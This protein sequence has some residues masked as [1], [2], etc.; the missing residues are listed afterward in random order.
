M[1][2]FQSIQAQ[3]ESYPSL[4]ALVWSQQLITAICTAAPKLKQLTLQFRTGFSKDVDGVI[5]AENDKFRWTE[6]ISSIAKFSSG[7]KVIVRFLTKY[8]FNKKLKGKKE[9]KMNGIRKILKDRLA[10]EWVA[11]SGISS[12]SVWCYASHGL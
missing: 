4:P 3:D 10:I 7:S 8:S 11:C 12:L 1:I 2:D 9:R 5:E 6:F